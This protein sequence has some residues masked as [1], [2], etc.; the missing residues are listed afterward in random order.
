[1]KRYPTLCRTLVALLIPGQLTLGVPRP[2]MAKPAVAE[3][4]EPVPAVVQPPG[5]LGEVEVNLAIPEV[6]GR[7]PV[8]AF[9]A[10]PTPQE[11]FS[12]RV[13]DEPLVPVAGLPE[14]QGNQALAAALLSYVH[15][16]NTEDLGPLERFLEGNPQSPWR[17]ALLTNMGVAYRRRGYL[18]RAVAAWDEAWTLAKEQ[19]E[20]RA[21]AIA[22]RAVSELADLY[23]RLGRH[24]ELEMLLDEVEGRDVRGSARQRLV[25]AREALWS[26]QNETAGV[27]FCGVVALSQIL[28]SQD[29]GQVNVP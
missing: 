25:R 2:A 26:T 6:A 20:P 29:P 23:G 14:P 15:G 27:Y 17:A 16:G 28:A 7:G 12:A 1:M 13:F 24:V 19:T 21:R 22:E 4:T 10:Q 5:E 9:S 18:S 8:P 11:L 3:T